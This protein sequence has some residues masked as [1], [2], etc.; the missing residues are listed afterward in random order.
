MMSEHYTPFPVELLPEPI[1]GYVQ[2]AARSI[3]C[4]PS[5]VALPLL[6]AIGAAIGNTRRIVLKRGASRGVSHRFYGRQPWA[7]AARPRA[8]R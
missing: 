8:R 5:Y 3:H 4:D 7:I 2:E 1:G 6:S